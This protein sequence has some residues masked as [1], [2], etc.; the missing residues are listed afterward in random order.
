MQQEFVGANPSL[1]TPRPT[2]ER[3]LY[4]LVISRK[5]SGRTRSEPVTD[6]KMTLVSIFGTWRAQGLNPSPPAYS[7]LPIKSELLPAGRSAL[8]NVERMELVNALA[9]TVAAIL[10]EPL[11]ELA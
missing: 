11:W 5:V 7:S 8:H 3:S 6:T 4:P 10:S 9:D 2:T 1:S